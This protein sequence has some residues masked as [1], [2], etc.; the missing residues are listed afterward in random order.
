TYTPHVA[1]GDFVIV[2]NADKVRFSGSRIAHDTHPNFTEK[3][4]EKTYEHYTGYPGGRKVET[5]GELLETHPQR[6]LYEAVRRMLPKNKL[7]SVMLSRLKLYAGA[8]HPHQAQQPQ[9]LSV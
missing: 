6:I 3:M 1:C 7:R 9:E 2:V 8:N 4:A 5:A